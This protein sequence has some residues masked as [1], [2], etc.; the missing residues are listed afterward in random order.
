MLKEILKRA[1]KKRGRWDHHTFK[2]IC[3]RCGLGVNIFPEDLKKNWGR[4]NA[5]PR[6]DSPGFRK[7][8]CKSPRCK[9]RIKITHKCSARE[10]IHLADI[11]R[12]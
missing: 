1:D 6:D 10:A 7:M 5:D 4:F 8:R 3:A 9:G 12:R 11:K 2:G